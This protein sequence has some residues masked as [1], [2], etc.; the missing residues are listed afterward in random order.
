MF[1]Y[2]DPGETL[3]PAKAL[4]AYRLM[5]H[6]QYVNSAK[7]PRSAFTLLEAFAEVPESALQTDAVEWAAFPKSANTGNAQI[8]A[9]RFT[10]QDEYVEWSVDRQAG[11][12]R[13]ITFTTE[14]LAY[15]EALA[16]ASPTALARAI[17]AV[18]DGA[19]P[20]SAELFGPGPAPSSLSEENRASRFR[21]FAQQNPWI[22]GE[23]SA[24]CLAHRNNTLGALFGLVDAAA[25][26]APTTPPGSICAQLGNAC[27]PER[28]S[29]PSIATAVQ[30]LS[31]NGRSL[32]LV[33]PVGVEIA[34]LAGIWRIGDD[35]IDVN[36]ESAN[37]GVWRVTRRGRRGILTIVPNLLLDDAPIASGAQVAAVLRVKAS[38]VSAAESDLPQWARMGQ[39]SS[40]RI[41]EVAGGAP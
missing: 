33:D 6:S 20:T 19:N 18:V 31:R 12:I 36:D 24:V 3:K 26:P 17:K 2:T 13:R 28:N 38:V 5:L 16:R 41:D 10:F 23:K 32:S 25:V 9:S 7:R 29:D 22:N 14:F 37:P 4:A 39:E 35:E 34:R 11:Q 8:D 15:Y 40:Q 1:Q 30:S 21:N 27:V